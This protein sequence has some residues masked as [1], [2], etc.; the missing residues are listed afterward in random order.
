MTTQEKLS[1]GIFLKITPTMWNRLDGHTAGRGKSAKQE[2]IRNGLV[3]ELDRLDRRSAMV[4][5][6]EASL[7]ARFK[8]TGGNLRDT[9][10]AALDAS[11]TADAAKATPAAA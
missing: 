3:N 11:V 9:L 6:E 7:I 10:V 1:E 2:L 4:S 5:E 8:L